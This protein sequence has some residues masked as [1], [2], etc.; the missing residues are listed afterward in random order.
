MPD[1]WSSPVFDH[2]SIVTLS[3]Y[4]FPF[5]SFLF[6]FR[7]SGQSQKKDAGTPHQN[8]STP[9]GLDPFASDDEDQLR[10]IAKKFEEKYVSTLGVFFLSFPLLN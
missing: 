4:L 3:D 1:L 10:N 9:A 8:G 6:L 2:G 7:G 5:F